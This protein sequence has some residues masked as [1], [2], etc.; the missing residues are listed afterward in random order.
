MYNYIFW[1]IYQKNI[2]NNKGEWLSRNN[3][4][5]VVFFTVFIHIAFLISIIEKIIHYKRN[6][7]IKANRSLEVF[8]I[9]IF[10]LLTNLYYNKKRVIKINNRYSNIEKNGYESAIVASLV[11]IPL[12]LFI[13]ILS[14]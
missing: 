8:I 10:L 7:N 5:G 2:N 4:S 14:T 3:A 13:I 9:I 1:V 12:L 6:K 11:F